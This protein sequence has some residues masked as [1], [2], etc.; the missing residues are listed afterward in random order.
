MVGTVVRYYLQGNFV[1]PGFLTSTVR[2]SCRLHIRGGLVRFPYDFSGHIPNKM[3]FRFSVLVMVALVQV[4]FVSCRAPKCVNIE[5]W[6]QI[7]NPKPCIE[8][9]YHLQ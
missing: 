4:R 8:L 2:T 7:V 9:Q 1:I 5:T 3:T 6:Y